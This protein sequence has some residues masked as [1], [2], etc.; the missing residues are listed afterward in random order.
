ML[1]LSLFFTPTH[2]RSTATHPPTQAKDA[3]LHPYF[4]DVAR[5]ALDTL[6]DADVNLELSRCI[7]S[8]AHARSEERQRQEALATAEA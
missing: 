6:E 2:T 5:E 1:G 3:L 4:D 8:L 7:N